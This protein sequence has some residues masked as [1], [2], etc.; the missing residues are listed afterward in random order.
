MENLLFKKVNNNYFFTL[1]PKCYSNIPIIDYLNESF[2][3]HVKCSHC[4]FDKYLGI[5]EYLKN[6]KQYLKC[7]NCSKDIK[8]KNSENNECRFIFCYTCKK[9]FHI[10][11]INNH[12]SSHIKYTTNYKSIFTTCYKHTKKFKYYC[13]DCQI[14]LCKICIN[15]HS[16][17]CYEDYTLLTKNKIDKI[18]NEIQ[19]QE[20]LFLKIE[21]LMKDFLS[22][23]RQDIILKKN[24]LENYLQNENNYNSITNINNLNLYLNADL[25]KKLETVNNEEIKDNSIKNCIDKILAVFEY[26]KMIQNVDNADKIDKL[27]KKQICN[28]NYIQLISKNFINDDDNY[29]FNNNKINN[30]N[31]NNQIENKKIE[32]LKIEDKNTGIINHIQTPS[33]VYSMISLSSGNLMIGLKNGIIRIYKTKSL[34]SKNN[35]NINEIQEINKFK[36]RRISYLFEIKEEK[37]ILCCTYTK[38]HHFKLINNEKNFIYFGC[39]TFQSRE[40]PIKLINLGNQFIVALTEIK[41][42]ENKEIHNRI[43]VFRINKVNDVKNEEVYSDF[44]SMDAYSIGSNQ[45]QSPSSSE[46]ISGDNNN[47]EDNPN[48]KIYKKNLNENDIGICSIFDISTNKNKRSLSMFEFIATS[49]DE[50]TNGEN[51]IKF[52]DVSKR[53]DRHGVQFIVKNEIFDINCSKNINSICRI[54]D[55]I[56]GVAIQKYKKK[57]NCGIALININKKTVDKIIDSMPVDILNIAYN[58]KILIYTIS[59]LKEGYIKPSGLFCMNEMGKN[60]EFN[61]RKAICQYKYPFNCNTLNLLKEFGSDRDNLYYVIV[62]DRNIF[63]A[64]KKIK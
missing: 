42:K 50:L 18:K 17:H 19:N 7:S 55:S 4:N 5:N 54:N 62:Y 61:N 58:N 60:N 20:K 15:D 9:I 47:Y 1:C 11:C 44:E 16:F 12:I 27:L 36:G 22:N 34:C 3:I 51:K 26:Y 35:E 41:N 43:E 31:N 52:Y 8:E 48:I 21:K 13:K 64:C 24:I 59:Y 40:L 6:E 29:Q 53:N 30:F 49:N 46:N 37:T 63:I 56:I 28:E 57:T 25:K 32:N 33:K 2:Q 23:L 39:N 14:P 10:N 45:L 38:M